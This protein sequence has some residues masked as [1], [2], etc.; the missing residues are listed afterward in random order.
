MEHI[1]KFKEYYKK[2][3]S[4]LIFVN[5]TLLPDNKSAKIFLYDFSTDCRLVKHMSHF[6]EIYIF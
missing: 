5:E 4:P 2:S 1:E 6:F 3:C